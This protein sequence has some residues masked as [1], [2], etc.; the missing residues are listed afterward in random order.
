MTE[1]SITIDHI[2]EEPCEATSLTHGSEAERRGRLLRLG[3]H[4]DLLQQDVDVFHTW[5]HTHPDIHPDLFCADLF[6]A[7]LS[8]IDLSNA[9]L[10]YATLANARLNRVNLANA[11]L[12]GANLV[13]ARLNGA[14]LSGTNF[15]GADLDE[16]NFIRT[17]LS[18]AK[19][20]ETNFNNAH[21]YYTTFA[22][23]DL[24]NV[25]RLET[26]I[27]DGPST[28]N[29]NSVVLPTDESVRNHFLR[30]VGFTETQTEYLPFLLIS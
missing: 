20:S 6:G 28:V 4:L 30:G 5:R 10:N 16:A 9:N 18:S 8:G 23:N 22:E 14:K 24:N 7:N 15:I 26:T 29:I 2:L 21:F 19:L 1:V 11:R 17:N 12:N 25:K 3:N 27:H 13:N